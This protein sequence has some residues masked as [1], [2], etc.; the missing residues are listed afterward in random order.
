MID[1][2]QQNLHGDLD[3]GI[4]AHGLNPFCTVQGHNKPDSHINGVWLVPLA[5]LLMGIQ[6]V[7]K[8][9]KEDLDRSF[10]WVAIIVVYFEDDLEFDKIRKFP[11]GCQ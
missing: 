6:H 5:R 9:H 3:G 8:T 2:F 7:Y 11:E 10:D 1:L 4:L